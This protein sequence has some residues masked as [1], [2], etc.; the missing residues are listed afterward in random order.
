M[1]STV[2]SVTTAPPGY[3][4]SRFLDDIKKTAKAINASYSESSVAIVL[5][6]FQDFFL[7][8]VIIFRTTD[9]PRDALNYRLFIDKNADTISMA[10][11][12]NL[13]DSNHTMIVPL[14]IW[15]AVYGSEHQQWCDFDANAGLAKTWLHFMTPRPVAEL[16]MVP[17]ISFSLRSHLPTFQNLNL[18]M[19]W[20]VSVD[21]HKS[22]LNIY[23]MVPGALFREHATR[24]TGL[25]A[26]SPLS[27]AEFEDMQKYMNP[28]GYLFTVT[29]RYPEA[30]IPR[31][32]FYALNLV[33]DQVKIDDGPLREFLDV[34]P[35]YDA[36]PA[37]ALAW[38]FGPGGDRYKKLELGY[39]NGFGELMRVTAGRAAECFT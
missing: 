34:C 2:T 33:P 23:F 3:S 22:T 19:V 26:S 27:E 28:H 4:R 13:L 9:R 25:A 10:K 39:A 15:C 17:G 14:E 31:V 21:Y 30:T 37:A 29:L 38:S 24:L 5:D 16:L 36:R 12:A 1:T 7:D 11:K 20:F 18:N 35:S 32:A 8:E 6:T